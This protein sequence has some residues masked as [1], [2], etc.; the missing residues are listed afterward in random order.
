MSLH[1]LTYNLRRAINILG[2]PRIME[3]LQI[4]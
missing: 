4:A 3:Q 1:V 2:V